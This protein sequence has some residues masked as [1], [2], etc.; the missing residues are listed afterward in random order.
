[1]Q[2]GVQRQVTKD[3]TVVVM[4]RR[5]LCLPEYA[6]YDYAIIIARFA[7]TGPTTKPFNPNISRPPSF[8]INTT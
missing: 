4:A 8:E 2:A 7:F 5:G 6:K 1:M 3:W